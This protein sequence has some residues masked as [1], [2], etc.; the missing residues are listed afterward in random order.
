MSRA[1]PTLV[2]GGAGFVGTNLADRL[3]RD[4]R[5][6][7][8]LDDLSRPG[9]ERNLRWLEEEHGALLE[10]DVADLRHEAAVGRATRHVDAI[11]HFAAQV[12]VTT[13]LD[14]P[15]ED[16][17]INIQGTLNLLEEARL[18]STPL[19]FT[20]TNKVYGALPGVALEEGPRR[21]EPRAPR[22]RER[23]IGEDTA[24][25]FCTPYGCSK[26]A[27]DQY[28]IDYAG[29]FGLPS[30]VFRMSC[31]YGPHQFG[32][33]DQGW[34]AH[35]LIRAL[36]GEPITIYGDG[37]QVRDVLFVDDLID[38]LLIARRSIEALAGRAFNIGGGPANAVSLGQ[39]VEM[40]ADLLG[41]RPVLEHA[42]WRK[43]DQR[44]YVSDTSS[45]AR[46]TGWAPK[47]APP[48]GLRQ[49]QRWLATEQDVREVAAA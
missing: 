25:S 34:V 49:L 4:G 2:T 19:I 27:A 16:A 3:L 7:R 33:E 23:G 15:M 22:L 37:K 12:A 35:F 1:R 8:V 9:V 42:S 39:V 5:R 32:N 28:V 36:Q 10:V 44:W 38:A 40:I 26:G 47:V 45:F 31:I 11:F 17:A 43:G 14:A 13:S 48:D 46:A 18:A 6:V 30:A 21:W 20:S 29:S 41:E 24:L